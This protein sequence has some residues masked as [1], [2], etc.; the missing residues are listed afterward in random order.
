MTPLLSQ[1][2]GLDTLLRVAR[3]GH[4]RPVAVLLDHAGPGTAPVAGGQLLDLERQLRET[5]RAP[6][7]DH[8]VEVV[9]DDGL[10][11]V[12]AEELQAV[13]AVADRDVLHDS[14]DAGRPRWAG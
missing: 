5:S 10:E 12:V 8:P 4:V 9:G 6:G 7:V 1:S 14:S 3:R 2:P 13:A 11:P